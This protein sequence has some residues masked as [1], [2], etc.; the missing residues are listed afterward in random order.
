MVKRNYGYFEVLD[1]LNEVAGERL[2]SELK[3]YDASLSRKFKAL[4]LVGLSDVHYGNPMFSE[5]HF[6]NTLNVLKKVPNLYAVLNGDMIETVLKSSVGDIYKQ[7]QSPQEQMDYIKEHLSPVRHKIL[8]ATDGNHERR[9]YNS[10]GVDLLQ[11]MCSEMGIPYRQNGI[12]LRVSFGD[13]NKGVSGRPYVYFVYA[14][15]GY[16]TARTTGAKAMKAE[17]VAG[18]LMVDVIFMSHDHQVNISPSVGLTP[19]YRAYPEKSS[20]GEPTG[21]LYGNFKAV[22]RMPVK[23]NAFI[24]WGGYAEAGGYP[25]VDLCAPLVRFAGEGHPRVNV[26]V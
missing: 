15:H 24:K 17:R 13:G 3:W 6:V 11:Q 4:Y 16:G 5:R 2:E 20:S 10:T 23:T 7:R 26:A 25:P 12:A 21:F 14:T 9:I 18:W 19:D 8:G 1:M 22:R